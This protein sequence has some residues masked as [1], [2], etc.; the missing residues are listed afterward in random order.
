MNRLE[1]EIA[2]HGLLMPT[3]DLL[4][5]CGGLR[6][7]AARLGH[8][9]SQPIHANDLGIAACAVYY[10]LPLVTGNG[11]HFVGLPGLEVVG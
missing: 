11:R 10:R 5:L 6:T 4:R 9:L 2:R 1:S 7:V 8:P 3:E